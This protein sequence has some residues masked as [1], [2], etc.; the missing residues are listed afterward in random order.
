MRDFAIALAGLNHTGNRLKHPGRVVTANSPGSEL[1]DQNNGV[2]FYMPGQNC[3]R[4]AS[5]KNLSANTLSPATI[6]S[7]MTQGQR[8]HLKVAFE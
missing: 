2:R 3:N 8:I 1:L 7:P 6:E 5:L 4:V